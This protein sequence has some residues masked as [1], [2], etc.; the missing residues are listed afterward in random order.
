MQ[1]P[2][3]GWRLTLLLF[4]LTSVVESFGYSHLGAFLPVYI[5]GMDVHHPAAWVGIL[6]ALTFVVGLPLVPLWGVWAQRYGNKAV[7]VRSACVEAVVFAVLAISHSLPGVIT[8]MALTGL[9][10][11]NTG[12]MLS[13]LRRLVPHGR[14]GFAV[15]V[16][17]TAS[18][19]GMALG[20]L[21]GGWLVHATPLT[22]HHLYWMDGLLSVLTGTMLVA[23]YKEPAAGAAET[24]PPPTRESAWTAAWASVRATFRLRVAWY[25]FGIYL[26]LMLS[27]QMV[28]PFVPVEIERIHPH[29]AGLTVAIGVVM[30]LT[31]LAGAAMAIGAGRLGDRAG[32]TKVLALAFAVM[33][34]SA[35]SL[36]FGGNMVWLGVSLTLFSAAVSTGGAMIF[37][38][39]STRIPEPHRST[40]LNLVYLPMYVGG[41]AGPLLASGLMHFGMAGP[42]TGAAVA[43]L[44]GLV[45]IGAVLRRGEQTVA[46][47]AG[48]APSP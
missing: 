46:Q 1:R 21:A 24:S 5:E 14:V 45:V 38:L 12:I 4:F 28:N 34:P 26:L 20:P 16:F 48:S 2:A 9:Q 8:A 22:L 32:F 33:V 40:A 29:S 35:W 39:F 19:V 18:P 30:G 6:N 11:G 3:T 15:S 17:S 37:A 43:S 25:L 23:L 13:S 41:I 36:G 27:R 7:I 31:A 47:P 42:F 44:I 10:L